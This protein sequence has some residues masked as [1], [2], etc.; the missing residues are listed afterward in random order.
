MNNLQIRFNELG[1]LL[2]LDKIPGLTPCFPK[3]LLKVD[4]INKK[5]SYPLIIS[6]RHFEH[7]R[8]EASILIL[9]VFDN[10]D[11]IVTNKNKGLADS[12]CLLH[13]GIN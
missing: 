7:L 12:L 10:F 9:D 2:D 13:Q 3:C 11:E 4:V 5:V 8:D 1:Y 6:V